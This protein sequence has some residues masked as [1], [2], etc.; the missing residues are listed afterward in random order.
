MQFPELQLSGES[1]FPSKYLFVFWCIEILKIFI[2]ICLPVFEYCSEV[3]C[4][5]ADLN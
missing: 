4:S 1:L 5:A 2:E 3:W